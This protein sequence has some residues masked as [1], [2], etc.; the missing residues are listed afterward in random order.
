MNASK[1]SCSSKAFIKLSL[2]VC[3]PKGT[4]P[5]APSVP[6]SELS[7]RIHR[8]TMVEIFRAFWCTVQT[9]ASPTLSHSLVDAVGTLELHVPFGGQ[10]FRFLYGTW[11]YTPT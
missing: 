2:R 3:S 8:R 5:T 6:I 1:V 11:L 4:V 9:R 10:L 7:V